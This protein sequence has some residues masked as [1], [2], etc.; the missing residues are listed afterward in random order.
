MCVAGDVCTA[1]L[2]CPGLCG[3]LCRMS[4][5]VRDPC[6]RTLTVQPPSLG[7]TLCCAVLCVL[8]CVVLC[9]AVLRRSAV[10]CCVVL[11]RAVTLTAGPYPQVGVSVE[12]YKFLH[13]LWLEHAPIGELV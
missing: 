8:C 9:W 1:V 12:L 13:D 11:Y 3:E 6:G 5:T 7:S 4:C 10:S 2:L